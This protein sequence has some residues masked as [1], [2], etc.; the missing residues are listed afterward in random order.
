MQGLSCLNVVRVTRGKHHHAWIKS[1]Q[2][3]WWFYLARDDDKKLSKP[4]RKGLVHV[5]LNAQDT[6][7]CSY[8]ARDQESGMGFGTGKALWKKLSKG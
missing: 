5:L 1:N 6:V 8:F 4:E 2:I 3:G 7:L